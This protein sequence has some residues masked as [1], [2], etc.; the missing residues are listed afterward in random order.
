MDGS[1]MRRRRV[2]TPTERVYAF[3]ETLA[4]IERGA[5]QMIEAEQLTGDAIV[6]MA[7][8]QLYAVQRQ[9]GTLVDQLR[10]T[11]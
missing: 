4:A 2:E 8:G 7:K 6:G 11:L 10:K 1:P 9:R 5:W 3:L